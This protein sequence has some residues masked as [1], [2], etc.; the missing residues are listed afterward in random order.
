MTA[1]GD[2]IFIGTSNA[3]VSIG[4]VLSQYSIPSGK[5]SNGTLYYW[6]VRAE[7][8]A[9]IGSYS[10]PYTFTTIALAPDPPVLS[11]PSSG[12]TGIPIMPALEW[13][14]V[15]GAEK[16]FIQ[17]SGDS[18]FTAT[19]INDS[20]TSSFYFIPSGKLA[21]LTKYYWRAASK[22]AGG[23]SQWST[24]FNFTTVVSLPPVVTLTSPSNGATNVSVTPTMNWS[25]SGY[26]Y[27][28][29]IA[30][31][32]NFTANL[33]ASTPNQLSI[34][35]NNG[36]NWSNYPNPPTYSVFQFYKFNQILFAGGT[37]GLFKTS[38]NGVNW[39]QCFSTYTSGI[40]SIGNNLFA[41]TDGGILR[42]SNNGN[43]WNTVNNGLT[44]VNIKSIISAGSY[45][46]AG[47]NDSGIF[48]STNMGNVWIRTYS[49]PSQ[50]NSL[51]T[52]GFYVYAG[53][54]GTNQFLVS[55][56]F[57]LTWIETGSGTLELTK[58]KLLS[59]D[60][61]VLAGTENGVFASSNNGYQWNTLGLS[62]QTVMSF[63]KY[64]SYIFAATLSGVYRTTNLGVN[65][66][67]MNS[68]LPDVMV[69]SI[70][71]FNNTVFDTTGITVPQYN[72]QSGLLNYGTQYYWRVNA[73]NAGGTSSW[74]IP[75][76]FTTLSQV[77]AVPVLVSPMNSS[78]GNPLSLNLIWHKSLYATNYHVQVSTDTLFATLIVNDSTLT[79]SIKAVSGL[80][81]LTN[82]YWR[83]RAKNA[84]GSSA[85]TSRWSF[86]TLGPPA[87]V[88]LN[89]PLNNSVNQPV[90]NVIFKWFK[91]A[92]QTDEQL[93]KSNE[94]QKQGGNESNEFLTISKYWFEYSTDSNF[95]VSI[96][97]T[98]LTDTL[99]TLSG[100][101]NNT[102]YYWRVNAKN[103]IGWG[104][105]SNVW[106]F[107]TTPVPAPTTPALVSPANNTIDLI[108]PV[109]LDWSTSSGAAFYH[110]QLSTNIGFTSLIINDSLKNST[111]TTITNLSS[112]TNYYWRVR[113]GNAGGYSSFT[114]AWTFRTLGLPNQVVLN[115]PP[116][117]GINIPVNVTFKW[118][119]PGEQ[120]DAL[121][122]S[123]QQEENIN[124]KILNKLS[125]DAILRNQLPVRIVNG[126][127][128]LTITK[129]W[130]EYSTD[131]LFA[132]SVIDTT[133][134]DTLKMVS[135]LSFLT[136]Y[137][138][139]VKAKNS[140]GWGAFSEVWEFRTR[141]SVIPAP[142]LL[143]PVNGATGL[144]LTPVLDWDTLTMASGYQLQLSI[145]SSFSTNII[146]SSNIPVTNYL[147][148]VTLL[149]D[150]TLYYWRVRG[151][152]P[153]G[154][155]NWSFVF[156][157]RTK[158][159]ITYPVIPQAFRLYENYPNPFN[160]ATKIKFDIPEPTKATIKIYDITGREVSKLL[161]RYLEAGT[162]EVDFNA[163]N[164]SSGVYFYRLETEK[165]T[166]VKRMVL[167]K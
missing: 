127:D 125:G 49:L 114:S 84:S 18:L 53:K 45:L 47:S 157:F 154:F 149:D 81:S 76:N 134:T 25:T 129:Y 52:N 59:F 108:P 8:I 13:S 135:N 100:L 155:G 153:F 133:V 27:G 50:I 83:V 117:G 21:H 115:S 34:S 136:K 3:G 7:N 152:N 164:L 145:D 122:N 165:Y 132:S 86:R 38:N 43:N 163:V 93:I 138:W 63:A 29:Q 66:I 97:D 118:Y 106:N 121:N 161:E 78:T 116:N 85:F 26:E 42:S 105:F 111:D 44:S 144:T 32:A 75:F 73:K 60:N 40:T 37:A 140:M 87:Q 109:T 22:G 123:K 61:Y 28:L 119:K 10:S 89:Q 150:T 96:I 142:V 82:Y 23:T 48:R 167:I 162:Y 19:I 72:V 9:G 65:W 107:T 95:A 11:Y 141:S 90:N 79:D 12:Q 33:I 94:L 14:D 35:T 2:S 131:S 57:G 112:Y 101:L 68:G 36:T 15:Q 137:Y 4:N 16:Y 102:K 98:T 39:T 5:L 103:E 64:D 147:V 70:Y 143:Q 31:D 91:P 17:L 56:D 80:S 51:S 46:V 55:N 62:G 6:R 30:T 69:Y 104:I 99:K 160:P 146:D 67:Q 24:I 166:N 71:N 128:A 41:A 151:V 74:S 156:N 124:L 139:R 92:E 88:T 120:T 113:A 1:V 148:P 77:P 58:Y 126:S 159:I 110:I 20:N 54:Y 158:S 130:F